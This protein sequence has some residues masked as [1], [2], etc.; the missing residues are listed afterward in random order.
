MTGR[1]GASNSAPS[2]EQTRKRCK[3]RSL[4]VRCCPERLR[5]DAYDKP[6]P[7][8]KLRKDL[9]LGGTV[10]SRKGCN[11]AMC[12]SGLSSL[13]HRSGSA[14]NSASRTGRLASPSMQRTPGCRPRL[15][16]VQWPSAPAALLR[17]AITPQVSSPR[18]TV[19][20]PRRQLATAM[21]HMY[22]CKGKRLPPLH[23]AGPAWRTPGA[24]RLC[25]T[26]MLHP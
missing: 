4:C 7:R 14:K 6:F 11:H 8:A 13:P 25:R 2:L 23:C 9:L 19:A 21:S 15:K 17:T 12:S 3:Q 24:P 22:D 10:A 20:I 1:G 26:L 18:R 16:S 5:W